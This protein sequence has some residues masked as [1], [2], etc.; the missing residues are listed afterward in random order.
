MADIVGHSGIGV[1]E[2]VYDHS[3]REDFRAALVENA[4]ELF[5]NV[6]K[7]AVVN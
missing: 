6:P 4:E 2:N 7:S 5:R 1:T 3:D